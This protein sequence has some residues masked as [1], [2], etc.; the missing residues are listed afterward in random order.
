MSWEDKLE[1]VTNKTVPLYAMVAILVVVADPTWTSRVLGLPLIAAGEALRFWATGHLR[2]NEEL[3]TSGPYGHIQSPLYLASYMIA[4]GLCLMANN[5]VI[6]VLMSLLY[7]L[8]YI[9]RK[10]DR[11]WGRL[12]RMFGE[13]FMKYKSEVPYMFPPRM[14]PY[15]QGAKHLWSFAAT[16]ENTEHQTAI[17]V[18][19]ITFF[20]F[21]R[22]I[23]FF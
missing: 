16:I 4:T 7:F 8:T 15:P 12:E 6:W 23:L 10:K 3:T 20:V 19:L 18:F 1:K 17:A 5:A 2:K 21:G 9:P 22:H 14:D 11:E 13:D